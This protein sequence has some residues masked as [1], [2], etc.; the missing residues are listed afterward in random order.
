MRKIIV[1]LCG[2][3]L[4]CMTCPAQ[5]KWSLE[6]CI[7]Y[8]LQNNVSIRKAEFGSQLS[9]LNLNTAQNSRLPSVSGSLGYTNYFGRGPSRDGTYEDNNRMSASGS[10]SGSMAIFNGMRVKHQI[11]SLAAGFKAALEDLQKAK[12]DVI[13]N[14]TAYYLQALQYKEL[15]R[16]AA[17]Q[18]D[19]SRLQVDR[20]RLL[21]DIGKMLESE[22]LDSKALWAQDK[23]NLTQNNNDLST[24]LL[25]LSQ[26]LNRK[27]A[28]DFDV[29]EPS[30]DELLQDALR[31]LQSYDTAVLF[32]RVDERPEIRSA[33]L[34][35]Q[36]SRH[37][38]RVAQAARYPAIS[39]SG[40]Y[41]NSYYYSFVTGY[42]NA[43]FRQQL[44][45]NGSQYVGL[46][47]SIPIFN[48]LATR[49]RIR[50]SRIDI[51]I[52]ELVLDETKMALRKEIETA[53]QNAENAYQKYLS[54]QEACKAASESFRY[55]NE[56]MKVG[57]STML[58][59]NNAKTKM[60]KSESDRVRAKYEVI[61]NCKIL[62]FYMQEKT[63]GN[64]FSGF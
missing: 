61:F 31:S 24:A 26:A 56:K 38:L 63:V 52:Q 46:N 58:D 13:L 25:E 8:A 49:N 14:I 35:L 50:A 34:N 32:A 4:L 20:S 64:P 2:L 18:A 16:I 42:D 30:D 28:A 33:S 48:G 36:S 12:N 5:E 54:A 60:E 11:K 10:I 44:K 6:Q 7:D 41:S 55:E 1:G 40:G 59:Y 21:V 57:R 22:L 3:S 62:D 39:L 17:S 19:L 27:S 45:N 53:L 23:L 37:N 43:V 47:L 15:V 51:R 9:G 29:A